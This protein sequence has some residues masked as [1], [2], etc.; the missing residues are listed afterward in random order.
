MCG[1]VGYIGQSKACPILI[2]GL[3]R[4]EYREY[5]SAGV[6]LNYSSSLF[7]IFTY[8][9]NFIYQQNS[10]YLYRSAGNNRVPGLVNNYGAC[11]INSYTL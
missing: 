4:L 10:R 6:A 9:H 8:A 7:K 3:K 1:I 11:R 5:D 2:K